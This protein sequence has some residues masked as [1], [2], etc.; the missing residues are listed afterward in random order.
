MMNKPLALTQQLNDAINAIYEHRKELNS[1][2]SIVDKKRMDVEHVME[3]SQD[4]NASEGYNLYK[5]MREVLRERRLIK[6][7]MDELEVSVVYLKSKCI[8]SEN[9]MTK[10]IESVNNK[11]KLHDQ[12]EKI[13][14]YQVRVMTEVFGNTIN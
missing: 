8:G 13:R 7:E 12:D 14:T 6:D 1:Q 9:N 2:L 10:V 5:M 11:I 3:L 4:K